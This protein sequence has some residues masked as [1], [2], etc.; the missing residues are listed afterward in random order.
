MV[1]FSLRFLGNARS[2]HHGFAFGAVLTALGLLIGADPAAARC[3]G[4]NLLEGQSPE[5]LARLD[6]AMAAIPYPEGILWRATG[7]DGTELTLVGTLHVPDPRHQK[8]VDAVA[9]VL[10]SAAMLVV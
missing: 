9:P 8:T 1:G 4:A 6:A 2:R 10:D 5:A 7:P 3:M